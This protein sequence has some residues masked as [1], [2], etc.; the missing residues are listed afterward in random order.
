MD[1][2][3]DQVV[4]LQHVHV[5][6]AHLRGEGLAGTAIEEGRLTVGVNEHVAIA[7][8]VAV[9]QQTGDFLLGGTVEYRG[10][11]TGFLRNIN[12]ANL[13]Q[14]LSPIALGLGDIPA[15][16]SNPARCISRTCPTFIREGT[17]NG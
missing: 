15:G 16:V 10:G 3:V 11:Q 1:L 9:L 5:A 4:Q 7:G 6:D 2:V 17:P 13:A 14:T 8:W 12:E